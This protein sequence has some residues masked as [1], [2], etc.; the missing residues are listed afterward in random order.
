VNGEIV[1]AER[2]SP[3]EVEKVSRAPCGADAWR[4]VLLG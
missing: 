2:V 1:A 3:R 4:G